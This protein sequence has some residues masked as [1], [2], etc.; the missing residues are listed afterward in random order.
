MKNNRCNK[1]PGV[2]ALVC[3][4]LLSMFPITVFANPDSDSLLQEVQGDEI[5]LS[6]PEDAIIL[7]TPEDVCT[8]A[9]NCRVS[10]W[11]VGKTVVLKNDIDMSET[12]FQ[13]IPTSVEFFWDWE[14]R[15]VVLT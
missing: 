10:S 3:C 2:V 7:S 6:I 8:L 11:S 15:L 5:I 13:G 9:E 1:I 14:I 4:L 12:D